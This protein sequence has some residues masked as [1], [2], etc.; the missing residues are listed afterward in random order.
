MA[1]TGQGMAF[2]AGV[3]IKECLRNMNEAPRVV[4]IKVRRLNWEW[5]WRKL[6]YF[7]K[8]TLAMVNR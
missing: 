6:R 2:S 1:R 3:D 8:P 7:E 5:Q 4:S